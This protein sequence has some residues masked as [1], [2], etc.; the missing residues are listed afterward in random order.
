MTL[1]QGAGST[2]APSAGGASGPDDEISLW[3]VLAVLL[4]RSRLIVG[5]IL[6]VAFV[7][8]LLAL[9]RH[10]TWTTAAA[11]SPQGT[12]GSSQL[13]SLASQFGVNVG[14]TDQE[15]NPAFYEELLRSREIL[16]RVA[17]QGYPGEEGIAPLTDLLE[18]EA[19]TEDLRLDRATRW[20]RE[21][22]M[23]VSVNWDNGIVTVEVTTRWPEVSEGIARNL[24]SEVSRFN[25]ET[26][27]S[28]AGAERD[29][30]E[31]R[32]AAAEAELRRSEDAL[33]DFLRNN[34]VIGEF[35]EAKLEFDRLTREVG[36]RQAV[37]GTLVQ[38]YEQARI[39]EVRDTPVITV[40]QS[41]YL[42]PKPDPRGL[43]LSVALGMILGGML[44]VILAFGAEVFGRPGGEADP[45][46]RDFEEAWKG[47]KRSLP[48]QRE[49]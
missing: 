30:I 49:S 9:L 40:L 38:S 37:Y 48:F 3:E 22:A 42:P 13:A 26:R 4:R 12:G 8:G 25:L 15:A 24:L 39:Q 2:T 33:Q 10:R 16:I 41:P 32:L 6:M 11:F 35:S 7:A 44:G 14:G 31:G 46:R 29:F 28:Q 17:R 1:E 45:A 23:S 34:R 18:I 20:L 21:S 5:S 47:L 43:V 27:Q 36:N 19:D